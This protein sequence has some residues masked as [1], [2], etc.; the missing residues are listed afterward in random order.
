MRTRHLGALLGA[1]AIVIGASCGG[2]DAGDDA[3]TTEAASNDNA[4]GQPSAGGDDTTRTSTSPAEGT[5][6]EP[7]NEPEGSDAVLRFA[8]VAPSTVDPH[9]STISS[10]LVVLYPAFD[11]LIHQA[12][13][14][15]SVPGLA[16][17][18]S[19]VDDGTVL[20]LELR[21]DVVFQDGTP[22]DAETVAF[23]IERGQTI[24]GSGVAADLAVIDGVEVVDQYTVRLQLNGPAASL[25]LVL[26]GAP[27]MMV[28]PES[29]GAGASDAIPSGAGMYRITDYEPGVNISYE[30]WDS[31]WDPE[32]ALL[33]GMEAKLIGD[34]VARLN[35]LR[36]DQLD[37]ALIEPGQADEA[38]DAGLDVV[39]VKSVEFGQLQFN[40]SKPPLDDVAVRR[41]ISYAIDRQALVDAVL[42]GWGEPDVQP[43]PEG[44]FAHSDEVEP[45]LYPYDPELARRTLSEAGYDDGVEFELNVPAVDFVTTTAEAIQAM[46]ADAGIDMKIVPVEV[47][48][49]GE[50]VYVQEQGDAVISTGFSRNDPSQMFAALFTDTLTNPGG[51]TTPEIQQLITSSL[52]SSVDPEQRAETLQELSRIV[53]EDAMNVVLFHTER[54]WA[55]APTVSGFESYLSGKPEFR[56]VSIE[57]TE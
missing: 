7:D 21:D 2:D 34:F 56:G 20:E 32:A 54:P 36:S 18:W 53:A 31:Y 46:L 26:S 44:F 24:E 33:G 27:G 6:D 9:L 48:Q 15:D 43:Y 14:G 50:L 37:V 22:F 35:G 39:N 40:R 11:R 1:V 17:A 3:D 51:A 28:S 13:N 29:V 55:T 52:D 49:F 47:S 57:E 41:A 38:G 25:P 16:S 10:D 45:D 42:F 12:P 4:D 19:F 8:W 5:G 30:A 23:N